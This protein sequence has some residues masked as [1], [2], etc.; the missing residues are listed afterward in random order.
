MQLPERRAVSPIV[1]SVALEVVG[2]TSDRGPNV[3]GG[4][5]RASASTSMSHLVSSQGR[6][7][8]F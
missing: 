8:S 1:T 2:L 5:Y 4:M 6:W 7:G 3:N